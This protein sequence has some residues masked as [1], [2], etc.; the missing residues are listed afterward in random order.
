MTTFD[1]SPLFRST[2]GFDRM[3]RLLESAQRAD[4]VNGYPP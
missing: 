1:F 4:E 3:Q 2:V